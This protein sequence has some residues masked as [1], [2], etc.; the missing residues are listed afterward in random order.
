M[1]KPDGGCAFPIMPYTRPSGDY[2]CGASGMS[3][4]DYFAGQALPHTTINFL[5]KVYSKGNKEP[6]VVEMP[7]FEFGDEVRM[8]LVKWEAE[9]AYALADAMIEARLKK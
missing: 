7:P 2:D 6:N 3:L 4:R 8:K 5:A 9:Y 1:A